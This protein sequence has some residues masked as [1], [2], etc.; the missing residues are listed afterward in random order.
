[1]STVP[2][3]TL[4]VKVHQTISSWYFSTSHTSLI[5]FPQSEPMF[6][7]DQCSL[8]FPAPLPSWGIAQL[9][10][11]WVHDP[12]LIL[13]AV[14]DQD[15]WIT[16]WCVSSSWVVSGCVWPNLQSCPVFLGWPDLEHGYLWWSLD[17]ESPATTTR[18]QSRKGYCHQ[19]PL[20]CCFDLKQLS[21][22]FQELDV[23]PPKNKVTQ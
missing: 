13:W 8:C 9:P 11:R 1:M 7:R 4:C 16:W 2:G 17:N 5:S 6:L 23:F 18:P 15:T 19:I 20:F 21:E 22:T 14:P 3:P 10:S 12:T